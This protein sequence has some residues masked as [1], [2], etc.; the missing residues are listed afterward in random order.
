MRA[1][2]WI[3]G[4]VSLPVIVLVLWNR[5]DRAPTVLAQSYASY[6]RPQVADADNAWMA[7]A[8]LGAAPDEEPLALARRRV[9]A[10]N[11]RIAQRPATAADEAERALFEDR[12]PL[13]RPDASR[14]GSDD[15]CPSREPDCLAWARTHGAMLRRLRD[16]NALRL[17]RY[18]KLL[19]L[20]GWQVRYP[21]DA[22]VP[23]VDTSVGVLYVN[24]VALGLANTTPGAAQADHGFELERLA[25][26]VAFWRRV[27]SEPQDVVTILRSGRMIENAYWILAAWLD[28]AGVE[29]ISTHADTI[30]RI[31]QPPSKPVDWNLEMAEEY[32]QFDRKLLLGLPGPAH[33]LGR[34]I[35]G[36]V[37]GGCVKMLLINLAFA[38]QATLNIYAVQHK[39][40]QRILEAPPLDLENVKLA[41]RKVIEATWPRFDGVGIVLSQLSYNYAGR[42]LAAVAMPA[43]DWGERE[44]DREALRRMVRIKYAA[45]LAR[46]DVK[47]MPDFVRKLGE[48]LHNPLSGRPFDWDPV[49]QTLHFAP[50]AVKDWK[51]ARVDIGY[52]PPPTA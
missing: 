37:E 5:I 39:E 9:D 26:H 12:L 7:F 45:R 13:V 19:S 43:F 51:R 29:E 2:A 36:T 21:P 4:I 1:L 48:P 46:I 8:G 40:M 18:G 22:D 41:A 44:H 50:R 31:L 30:D 10:L 49:L 47:D 28:R 14:D 34:C 24:L 17:Q 23:Y 3:V 16:A 52:R 25:Q 20:P 38:R 32:R 11:A 33:V 42:T 15:Y 35:S 27:R 6:S